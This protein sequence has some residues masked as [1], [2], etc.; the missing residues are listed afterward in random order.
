M[1]IAALKNWKKNLSSDWKI[2][3]WNESNIPMD[4]P[5]IKYWLKQKNYSFVSDFVRLYA[6]EKYGGVY[7][8]TDMFVQKP[9][10]NMWL[11]QDFCLVRST[12]NRYGIAFLIA[13]KN[14]KILKTLLEIYKLPMFIKGKNHEKLFGSLLITEVMKEMYGKNNQLEDCKIGNFY[15]IAHNKVNLDMDD[16]QNI[17]KHFY[18]ESWFPDS[19]DKNVK[20]EDVKEGRYYFVEKNLYL[21]HGFL[22]F[23]YKIFGYFLT[24]YYK[25]SLRKYSEFKKLITI[26]KKQ[27]KN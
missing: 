7:M 27:I 22:K 23:K 25:K 1:T 4:E 21:N 2:K 16:N 10:P 24:K 20:I 19:W 5:F 3:E 6:V 26:L 15:V 14:N 12:I 11:K 9:I 18:G 17:I 13:S 8:D